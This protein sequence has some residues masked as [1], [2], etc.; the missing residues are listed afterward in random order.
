MTV[1]VM[2]IG[3]VRM[4]VHDRVVFVRMAVR[5]LAI[6][7]EIVSVMVMLVV[8]MPMR[9]LERFVFVCVLVTLAQVQPDAD[10]HQAARDP[11]R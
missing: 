6:P 11:E 2:N 10:S 7:W 1:A 8:T 5:L 3:K 9:V 4:R